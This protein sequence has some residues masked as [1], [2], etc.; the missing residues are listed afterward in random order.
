MTF[1][2]VTIFSD[3]FSSVLAASLLGKAIEKGLV[4]VH[5]TD[6]RDFA[7]GR[8]RSVDDAPYGGGSGMVMRPDVLVAAIEHAEAARGPA[9]KVLLGPAGRPLDQST[10][11]QLAARPR[12]LLV[13]GRY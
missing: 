2:I 3:L 12:L 6:P 4:R 7:P 10:V 1:E 11:G 9:H 8:H 5:F 13:C